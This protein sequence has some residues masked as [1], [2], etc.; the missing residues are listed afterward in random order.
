ML[1]LEFFIWCS[2]MMSLVFTSYQ[3]SKRQIQKQNDRSRRYY[4][5]YQKNVKWID[6]NKGNA[7]FFSL[8]MMVSV[9]ALLLTLIHLQLKHQN[10][11]LSAQQGILCLKSFNKDQRDYISKINH[12]N[13]YIKLINIGSLGTK[14]ISII[15]PGL[16]I[17]NLSTVKALKVLMAYQ[18]TLTFLYL[19]RR[20]FSLKKTCSIL[21][22]NF[23]FYY[24]MNGLK[25]KRT[26]M[27]TTIL[28]KKQWTQ[29][30]F[31][32]KITITSKVIL[33]NAFQAPTYSSS[34]DLWGTKGLAY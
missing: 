9:L 14:I 24:Q 16:S 11:H 19:K 2:L 31:T 13:R 21:V 34:I 5:F 23:P 10:D 12:A 29:K 25:L 33:K 18:Q 6:P 20:F 15:L 17:A 1:L 27:G 22:D 7:T 4:Q 8:I 32:R 26:K 30:I 3:F 28:R